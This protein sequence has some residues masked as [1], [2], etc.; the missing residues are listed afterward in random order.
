MSHKPG[1]FRFAAREKIPSWRDAT[2]GCRTRNLGPAV[3]IGPDPKRKWDAPIVCN[4]GVTIANALLAAVNSAV[5][6]RYHGSC[7]W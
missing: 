1:L 5:A 4:E 7:P 3:E 6:R 2:G